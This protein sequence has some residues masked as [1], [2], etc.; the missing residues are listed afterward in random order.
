MQRYYPP[1][2]LMKPADGHAKVI[3]NPLASMCVGFSRRPVTNRAKTNCSNFRY[4]EHESEFSTSASIIVSGVNTTRPLKSDNGTHQVAWDAL[5]YW[6]D[7]PSSGMLFS[8]LIRPDGRAL[9][10]WFQPL[11]GSATLALQAQAWF[12]Q[13]GM[14]LR[15][16]LSDRAARNESSYRPDGIPNSWIISPPAVLEFVQ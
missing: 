12:M 10:E 1:V 8:A 13:W 5:E 11:G 7:Q 4:I 6:S 15:L 9:D 14:D 16:G 2:L 3:R